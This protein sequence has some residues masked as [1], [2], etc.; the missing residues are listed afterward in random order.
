MRLEVQT[1]NT[2]YFVQAVNGFDNV[3]IIKG[4]KFCPEWALAKVVRPI[5]LV[6]RLSSICWKEMSRA[7]SI[8]RRCNLLL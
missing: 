5:L 6:S 2:L 4:G 7:R 3:F 8:P 1:L